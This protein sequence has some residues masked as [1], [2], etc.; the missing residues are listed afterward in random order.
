TPRK[1][2]LARARRNSVQKVS[3]SEAPIAM[4]STSRRPLLLT[5]TATMTATETM[6]PAGA[7]LHIGRVEPEIG[8]VA[9]QRPIDKG[10]DLVVDLAAQPADLA[11]RD[12][13]HAHGFDQIIDRARRHAV[14][15]SLLDNRGEGFLGQAPRFQKHREAAALA[16]L[17]DAQLDRP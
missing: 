8:P 10:G 2:R 11:F 17:W 6:R 3:A 12:A 9:L 1:P 13:R 4:P 15:I 16:Q 7:D 14:H 5:A